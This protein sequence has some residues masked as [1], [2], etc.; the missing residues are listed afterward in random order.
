MGG[1]QF[2]EINNR[3]RLG[4]MMLL[5]HDPALQS[6][7]YF[8]Q[9]DRVAK[10]DDDGVT[11]HSG[12]GAADGMDDTTTLLYK[13]LP[14]ATP[15]LQMAV[16]EVGSPTSGTTTGFS[17][18]GGLRIRR[19]SRRSSKKQEKQIKQKKQKKRQSRRRL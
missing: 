7:R 17:L 1:H 14:A 4:Q 10:I 11:K 19:K 8:N 15:G 3:D 9:I 5:T 12:L 18:I 13:A 16:T 2:T 6:D